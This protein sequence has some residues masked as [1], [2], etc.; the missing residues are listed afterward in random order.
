M[1]RFCAAQD[2]GTRPL[3]CTVRFCHSRAA[4]ELIRLSARLSLYFGSTVDLRVVVGCL[5]LV[6]LSTRLSTR[7]S[8]MLPR[9]SHHLS[10]VPVN[11]CLQPFMA[12]VIGSI[13][14]IAGIGGFDRI[15]P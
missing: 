6:R 1:P 3:P 12:S 2:V 9:L 15:G 5:K 10:G 4:G 14:S 11:A 8:R 7:L 13:A